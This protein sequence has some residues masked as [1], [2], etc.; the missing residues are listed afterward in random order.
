MNN[1]NSNNVAQLVTGSKPDAEIAK[2]LKAKIIE[3]LQPA[4]KV[5]DEAKD[6]GFAISFNL[7]PD[8]MGKHNIT[9][10]QVSKLF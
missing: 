2:E 3:T 10:L 6:H 9:V 8:F 1:N 4:L 7:G 5:M